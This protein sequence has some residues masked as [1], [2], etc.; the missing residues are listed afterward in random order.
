MHQ[1]QILANYVLVDCNK[2][3]NEIESNVLL[4]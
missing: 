3:D 2:A 1:F 4:V